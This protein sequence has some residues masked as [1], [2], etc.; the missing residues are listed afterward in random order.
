MT[1]AKREVDLPWWQKAI[2]FPFL[3]LIVPPIILIMD[4]IFAGCGQILSWL[5]TGIWRSETVWDGLQQVS[6]R[7]N[8][9]WH[10]PALGWYVPNAVLDWL[11]SW[12]RMIGM[13]VLGLVVLYGPVLL[14]V[15]AAAWWES[16]FGKAAKR[17]GAS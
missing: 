3:L 2:L 7:F 14:F 5:R 8:L 1:G 13:P 4:G 9:N 16:R 10:R 12:P 6:N 15:I 11:L 17:R